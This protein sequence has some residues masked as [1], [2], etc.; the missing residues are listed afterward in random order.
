MEKEN[1]F[2]ESEDTFFSSQPLSS[3]HRITSLWKIVWQ[4][5]CW[6]QQR[7]SSGNSAKCTLILYDFFYTDRKYYIFF[8]I[9]ILY[10]L[11]YVQDDFK[12]VLKELLATH[13][14]LEFLQGTPEFQERYGNSCYPRELSR[15]IIYSNLYSL[16]LGLEGTIF[17]VQGPRMLPLACSWCKVCMPC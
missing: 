3:F 14:G 6:I 15:L 11:W 10:F 13:P 9:W 16:H 7:I 1:H 2:T 17:L 8:F 12:P 5:S 4:S